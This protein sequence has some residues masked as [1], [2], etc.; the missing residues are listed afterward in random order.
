MNSPWRR[1]AQRLR[2]DRAALLALAYLVLLAAAALLAP[3][4]A[5]YP[6]LA[7]DFDAVRQPP[8]PQHWLGTDQQGRDILS[9][10][11]YGARISLAV[12]VVSQVPVLLIGLAAGC[13]A[14]YYGGRSDAVIM[15]TV[16]VFYA[17]PSLL[18]LITVMAIL[19]RG[20]GPL[21][22]ALTLTAWAGLA[23]LVRGQVLQLRQ[24]EFVAA[25]RCVGASDRRIL[26][27]HLLPNLSGV[28]LVFLS[29]AI[30]GAI[31][32]EAGLSFLGLGLLP[33]APSWGIMLSDGFA[34]LRSAPHI[35]LFPGLA[36]A[37]TMLALFVLGDSLRDASDPRMAAGL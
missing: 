24:A 11:L 19:G 13:A 6:P 27:R 29:L 37:L 36:I 10:L 34:V 23:R 18:F 14:G 35:A 5:P 28:L 16:D 4:L 25:A 9:R 33:P 32:A 30:P 17:F 26:A 1:I 22:L 2:R 12:G 8:S 21:L 20:F 3:V 15:R 31:V 7:V